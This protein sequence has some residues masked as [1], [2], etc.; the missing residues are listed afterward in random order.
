MQKEKI[1]QRVLDELGLTG[2]ETWKLERSNS[3]KLTSAAVIAALLETDSVP[4]AAKT[5][6]IGYQTLNRTIAKTLVTLFGKATGGND[7]WKLKLFTVAGI[8]KCR[9][10]A[11]YKEHTEYTKYSSAFDGLDPV[12]R[13]CKQAKNSAYYETNKDV[14]HKQ[15]IKEHQQEYAARNAER[16]ARKLRATPLWANLEKIKEIYMS[17]PKG[18]HVDHVIPL[19][20]SH[21]CG[22]H[23]E[24]NLQ[25]ILAEE[26][27]RKS[28]SFSGD[29]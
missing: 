2:D 26:N 27:L 1:L 9:D 8:K 15:Y 14:Y 28:N 3:P 25:V 23:V 17:C 16:R 13:E 19:V 6:G 22:L 20:H 4:S 5:L 21:V 24:S 11:S 18:H 10:C 7:T 12:C 29:W